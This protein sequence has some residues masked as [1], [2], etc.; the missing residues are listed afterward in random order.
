MPIELI[1]SEIIENAFNIDYNMIFAVM[2]RVKLQNILLYI[3]VKWNAVKI[4]FK[5]YKERL[6]YMLGI[7]IN[8]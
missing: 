1:V 7:S 3:K 6:C 8:F 2:F 4:W 5:N